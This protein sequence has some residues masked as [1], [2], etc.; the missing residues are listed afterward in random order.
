MLESMTPYFSRFWGGMNINIQRSQPF[1]K[2]PALALSG[3]LEDG[4]NQVP[5]SRFFAVG[6]QIGVFGGF[7]K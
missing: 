7:L 4:L 3:F 2:V 1:N 5:G 6:P